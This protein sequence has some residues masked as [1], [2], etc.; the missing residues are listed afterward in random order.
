MERSTLLRL[1]RGSDWSTAVKKEDAK[2]SRCAICN[3][4]STD[5][6]LRQDFN[7]LDAQREA[8]EDYVKS[9]ARDAP[10]ENR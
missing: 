4:V 10:G 1:S 6:R 2:A 3:R 8:S 7:S 5:A 9:R